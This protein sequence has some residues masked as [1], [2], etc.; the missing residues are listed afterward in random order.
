MT[1]EDKYIMFGAY[2]LIIAYIFE[3][4][5]LFKYF[6]DWERKDFE[7]FIQLSILVYWMEKK[8]KIDFKTIKK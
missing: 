1:T 3:V 8:V 4:I 7:A 5:F 2:L 6:V